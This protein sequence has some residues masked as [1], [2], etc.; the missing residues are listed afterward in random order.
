MKKFDDIA[1]VIV[2]KKRVAVW[3]EHDPGVGSVLV[4]SHRA[5]N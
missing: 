2:A 5:S 4:E 1:K 3:Y